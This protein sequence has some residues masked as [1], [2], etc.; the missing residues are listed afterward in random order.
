MLT[1][2]M[3]PEVDGTGAYLMMQ[4]RH[5]LREIPVVMMSVAASPKR[6]DLDPSVLEFMSK[7]FSLQL[8]AVVTRLIGRPED[9]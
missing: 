2:V 1:D 6:P 3:M 8:V 4:A 9:T 5:N 7:P